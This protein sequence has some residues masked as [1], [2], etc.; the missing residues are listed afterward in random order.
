MVKC[1][2]KN[3]RA[4]WSAVIMRAIL[5]VEY[6]ASQDN[7]PDQTAVV[8]ASRAW[9]WIKSHRKKRINDFE[10]CCELVQISPDIIRRHVK[11][12]RSKLEY[13]IRR[14]NPKGDNSNATGVSIL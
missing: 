1:D 3:L 13:H 14:L 2:M 11:P 4:L 7:R 5:D 12:F 8:C 10:S 6:V 9:C